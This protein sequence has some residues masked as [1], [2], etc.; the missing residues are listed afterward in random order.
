MLVIATAPAHLLLTAGQVV[1]LPLQF[2]AGVGGLT[3][4]ALHT[5]LLGSSTSAGQSA[6]VPLHSSAAS[7]SPAAVLQTVL[8][9]L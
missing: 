2:C 1:V 7:Q 8:L 5:V 3:P 9:D 4:A 6:A